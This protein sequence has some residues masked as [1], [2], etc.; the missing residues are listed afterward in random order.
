MDFCFIIILTY[1]RSAYLSFIVGTG[2]IG[3]LKSRKLLFGA[4][5]ACLLLISFSDRAQER[6]NNLYYSAKSIITQEATE[7]P[8][9]TARLRVDSWQNTLIIIKDHPILGVG[10]NAFGFAQRR[11]GFVDQIETHSSTGSDSSLLTILATTGI[12]GFSA[13]LWIIVIFFISSL[14]NKQNPLAMGFLA[15]TCGLLI[16]SIFVN[17]LLFSPFLIF[18][19][20]ATGLILTPQKTPKQ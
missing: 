15:G 6:I 5:I 10:Y 14:K 4:L 1:S 2:L 17:S 19:Y 13:Y 8:D 9:A 3:L 16:H 7:L 20:T 18:F 11:Y 12:L